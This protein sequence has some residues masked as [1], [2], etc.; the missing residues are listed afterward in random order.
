MNGKDLWKALG[1]IDPKYI[2][3]AEEFPK[4]SRRP[5]WQP[6]VACFAV[7]VIGA[8]IVVPN[9]LLSSG[10]VNNWTGIGNTTPWNWLGN[11][12]GEL[13]GGVTGSLS[14]NLNDVPV[15]E[16]SGLPQ[17]DMAY[18]ALME[19]QRVSWTKE[20]VEDY[21]S[22][23][24]DTI[25]VPE[26]MKAE[27]DLSQGMSVWINDDGTMRFDGLQLYFAQDPPQQ[28]YPEGT[29]RSL[30]LTA[31]KIGL[32]NL[33]E[34]LYL[35][36]TVKTWTFQGTK[37]TIGYCQADH[38]PYDE[39]THAPAGTYPVYTAEFEY[40]GA[41]YRLIGQRVTRREIVTAVA[42]LLSQGEEVEITS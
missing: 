26:D 8:A 19:D 34:S 36:D 16:I 21:Y 28:E 31:S 39:T 5:R 27:T 20:Q 24:F 15:N 13:S 42:T 22:L 37:I 35:T 29:E 25:T 2:Q 30:T 32:L 6:A 10:I 40:N 9:L 11:S 17:G 12:Q 38:A 18:L 14:V 33:S 7:V 41:L 3:E 1:D 4:R 23:N